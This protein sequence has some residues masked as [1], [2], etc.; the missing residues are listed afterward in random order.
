[1]TGWDD[2]RRM[3]GGVGAAMTAAIADAY[4]RSADA[5]RSGPA[6]FYAA[7]ADALLD[8]SPVALAGRV[9]LDAGAGS[10]VA[11]DAARHR[12][13]SRVVGVDLAPAMLTGVAVAADLARLPFR[14]RTFDLAVAAFSIGHV[15]EPATALAQLRRV[16]PAL[17][18]S[19]FAQG[20]THPAKEVVERVLATH[21]HVPPA[22]YQDF[23]DGPERLVG[24]PDRLV[25]LATAA[26]WAGA[27]VEQVEVATGLVDPAGMV[28]WRLGMAHHAPF[29]AGLAPRA[30]ADVR[31]EAERLLAGAPSV[32]ARMLVLTAT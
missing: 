9:V 23:K 5:W 1:M 6:R 24:D 14:E 17:L 19:A 21:G 26:G 22:W 2:R 27:G 12:G 18:A 31:R 25:S 30:R 13:A 7:L 29:V 28:A 4:D 3:T 32:V 16:A 20:W 10:G 15:P 11:G 8:R